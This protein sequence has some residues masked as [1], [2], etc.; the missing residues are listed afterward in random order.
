MYTEVLSDPCGS[1]GLVAAIPIAIKAATESWRNQNAER[2]KPVHPGWV[3]VAQLAR[4]DQDELKTLTTPNKAFPMNG[5]LATSDFAHLSVQV[6]MQ[7]A[8]VKDE[9]GN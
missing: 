8:P 4:L 6:K 1:Y 5:T 2:R 9:Q 7:A 3:N